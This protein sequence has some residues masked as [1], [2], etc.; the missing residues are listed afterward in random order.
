[1]N[2]TTKMK[3]RRMETLRLPELQAKFRE[4]VGEATRA[5]SK[6]YLLRRIA[7]ALELQEQQERG[8]PATSRGEAPP[9]TSSS[10]KVVPVRIEASAL[11]SLDEARER[12][13][14]RT[15]ME[16]FRMALGIY[17]TAAGEPDVAQLFAEQ[18]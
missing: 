6:K 13:G 7:K 8:E 16:L 14:F 3:M 12:L 15:R 5:P 11:A 18:S 4:I 1:M 17:L 10:L 9:R 2:K